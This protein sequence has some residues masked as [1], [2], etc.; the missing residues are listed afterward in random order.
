MLQASAAQEN[1]NARQENYAMETL[2]THAGNH[3]EA[4]HASS[5]RRFTTPRRC[6]IGPSSRWNGPRRTGLR[7]ILRPLRHAHDVRAR[8]GGGGARGRR[9][10]PRPASGLAAIGATLAAA[11]QRRRPSAH[12]RQRLRPCAR[13]CD[14]NAGALS[15]SEVTYYDPV[16]GAGIADLMRPNTRLVYLSRR[17]QLTFESP[18]VPPRRRRHMPRA[19]SPSWTT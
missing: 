2:L 18:D 10:A 4:H 1:L 3:P 12:G 16:V 5:T 6:F 9:R 14:K 15:V 13:L 17:A 19:P 8:G 7:R 11:A